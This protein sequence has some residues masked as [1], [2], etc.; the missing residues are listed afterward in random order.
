MKVRFVDFWPG[1]DPRDNFLLNHLK[2]IGD[3]T[4]DDEPEVLFYSCYGNEY[5]KF[6][7]PR[8]FYSAENLRP[9]F[10]ACDFAITFDYSSD[11]RHF[12]Y[13]LFAVYSDIYGW[14]PQ[15]LQHRSDSELLAEWQM[16]SKFCAMVVSNGL[17]ARRNDFFKVLNDTKHVDS[18]GRFMNNVGGP[19]PHKLA[20]IRDYRFVISFENSSHPGYTT[21]KLIEPLL[22]GAIPIYWGNPDVAQ[23]FNTDRFLIAQDAANDSQ[24]IDKILAIDENPELALPY[25]R[26]PVFPNNQRSRQLATETLCQFLSGALDLCSS[27]RPVATIPEMQALHFI[28]R[29]AADLRYRLKSAFGKTYR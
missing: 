14:W 1:F 7:I 19:V 29:Q 25:L 24:L 17:S 5:R 3:F 8:L 18:G 11:P 20:F 2:T 21:E 27:I 16:K 9:D 23:E 4:V 12:R 10:S 22:T 15:L 26:Q 6:K 28:K 13:P